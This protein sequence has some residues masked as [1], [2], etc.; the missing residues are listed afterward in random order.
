[1]NGKVGMVGVGVMG[2]AMARNLR[3]A[4]FD[5]VGYDPAPGARERLAGIGGT[6]VEAPRL[7]AEAC[8][9]I[10]LSLPSAKALADAVGGGKRAG[11]SF[12]PRNSRDRV[13]DLATRR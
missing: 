9:T 13:L 10:I 11:G 7:V 12:G 3:Q 8:P 6:I 1:M 5:V 2:F 4:G